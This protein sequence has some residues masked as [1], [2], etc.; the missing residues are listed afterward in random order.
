MKKTVYTKFHNWVR[1]RFY[2]FLTLISPEL[3]TRFAYRRGFH[4][5]L[6]L[7][8]PV[9]LNE[10]LLKLKLEDYIK[11]PLVIQCADKYLARDYV[12]SQG[13]EEILIPLITVYENANQIE[14]DELPSQFVMKWNFGCGLNFICEDK[15]KYQRDTVKKQM[16]KWEHYKSYL[17]YSE[18]Q[19]K[20]IPKR[21]VV[22]KYLQSSNGFVP[23]DYKLYC[24]HGEPKF[25]MVCMG[26]EEEYKYGERAK[27]YFCD[28]NWNLARINRDSINAPEGFVP[29]KP[30]CFSQL[31]NYAQKLS[32]PFPFV[33]AD[34]YI[35]ED[36]IYFGE[37]TFTPAGAL[38]SA[39]LPETDILMGNMLHI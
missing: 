30:S 33:R 37:L 39:R 7:D 6:D 18:L 5:S 13:C 19:Y 14:W 25:I 10:K 20:Y 11:N 24:F 27:Y 28:T 3:N 29:P 32:K 21:I 2:R 4:K 26:R 23:D 17:D 34:F 36:K 31:L 8:N 22:E 15:S 12:R 9:T 38:D 16:K 1:I 35:V